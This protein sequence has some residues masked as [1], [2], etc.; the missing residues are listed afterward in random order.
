VGAN[1]SFWQQHQNK[2]D[3]KEKLHL[4]HAISAMHSTQS[5]LG[6]KMVQPNQR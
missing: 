5:Q 3:P 4:L 1:I 6:S 2:Q